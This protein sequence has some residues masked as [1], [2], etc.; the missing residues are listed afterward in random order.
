MVKPNGFFITELATLGVII[1]STM[2]K[3]KNGKYNSNATKSVILKKKSSDEVLTLEYIR[4]YGFLTEMMTFNSIMTKNPVAN[5]VYRPVV[6]DISGTC[7]LL[8]KKVKKPSCFNCLGFG[9]SKKRKT[10]R[11][12]MKSKQ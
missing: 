9:G 7:I 4:K 11:R 8:Q 2:Y 10:R 3:Y 6:E 1:N 12:A 5:S